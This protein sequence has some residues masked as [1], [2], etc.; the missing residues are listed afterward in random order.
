MTDT[1]SADE[2][3]GQYLTYKILGQDVLPQADTGS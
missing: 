3:D 2:H 1:L